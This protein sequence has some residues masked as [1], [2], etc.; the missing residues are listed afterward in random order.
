[1]I[2]RLKTTVEKIAENWNEKTQ[3]FEFPLPLK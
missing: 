3:D 1:L 2:N